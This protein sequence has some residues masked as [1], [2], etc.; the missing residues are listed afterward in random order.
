[1]APIQF[2]FNLL[3]TVVIQTRLYSNEHMF[4]FILVTVAIYEFCKGF[5][6]DVIMGWEIVF[7]PCVKLDYLPI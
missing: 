1:M 6:H 4:Y 3:V 5:I 2:N 7:D